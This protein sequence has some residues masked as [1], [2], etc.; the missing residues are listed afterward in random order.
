MIVALVQFA[1]PERLTV[2]QA[3]E[4]FASTAP[5]YLNMPGLVRKHYLLSEDGRTAGGM[6]V[7]KTRTDA[8]RQYTDEWRAFVRGKYGVEPQLSFFDSPVSVDNVTG[9]VDSGG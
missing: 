4:V 7:W 2:A 6:Y 3:R 8:E 1:L 5:R 9:T